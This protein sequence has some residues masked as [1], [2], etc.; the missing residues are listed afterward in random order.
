MPRTLE[1]VPDHPWFRCICSVGFVLLRF[2]HDIFIQTDEE[3]GR[4]WLGVIELIEKQCLLSRGQGVSDKP[5]YLVERARQDIETIAERFGEE[6]EGLRKVLRKLAKKIQPMDRKE[7]LASFKTLSERGMVLT[8]ECA[9]KWGGKYATSTATNLKPFRLA[10]DEPEDVPGTTPVPSWTDSE[11]NT[12]HLAVGGGERPLLNFLCFEFYLFHE[13]LSHIFPTWEDAA[14]RL[15]E[16]YLFRVAEWWYTKSV[17]HMDSALVGV[18][19]RQHWEHHKLSPVA[20]YWEAFRRRSD[21]YE[22]R[23][24]KEWS[25]NLLLEIAAFD[26][27]HDPRFQPN[28]LSFLKTISTNGLTDAVETAFKSSPRM[29]MEQVCD[30]FRSVLKRRIGTTT[31]KRI[32]L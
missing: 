27:R 16:G 23:T 25:S 2:R 11:D 31:L 8:R 10:F 20:D 17:D 9:K 21:W 28:A 4:N 22:A 30:H 13:Y 5:N 7:V 19:W 14:G 1:I 3:E 29:T 32:E 6:N 18:D 24:S 15:S 26:N 12:I